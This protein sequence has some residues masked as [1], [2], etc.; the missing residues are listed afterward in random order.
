MDTKNLIDQRQRAWDATK[1]LLD[2]A[3]AEK[4]DLTAEESQSFDRLMADIDG[5]DQR[6]KAIVDAESRERDIAASIRNLGQK[7]PTET[8]G[9][10]AAQDTEA[11]VRSFLRGERGKSFTVAPERRDLSKLSAGAGANTVKTSF[12]EQLLAHMIEVSGVMMAGPTILN[13]TSG[14]ALEIPITTSHSS[15]ALV[16][17]TAAIAESDPVFGKRTLG[18]YKYGVLIQVSN[19]LV[20]DASVDLLGYLSMQAGRA[21]GNALGVH[22]VTG[23]GSSQPAGIVTGST[24]GVTGAASVAGAPDFDKLIDLQYSVIA[25]YRNSPSCAW[26]LRDASVATLRK[27]KDTTGQYIWQPSTQV[28]SPDTMLGKPVFTDP[29]FAAVALGAKSIVFGDISQYF[30]RLAGGVRFERS[31]DYA[32]N[33][34]LV[35]FRCLVR[36]DGILADQTGAVKH[37]IGN[38]A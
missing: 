1:A 25:P 15:G 33:T 28:G 2:A 18:A 9:N 13:T 17:E 36:G 12:Y 3:D 4:R 6:T 20:A 7:P 31:D 5:L 32:F 38:A 21:V 34:D 8:P 10:D 35:T 30:V 27:I 24:L 37:F 16:A 26:L 22:L 14:E 23:S 11:E 29:N 19:E